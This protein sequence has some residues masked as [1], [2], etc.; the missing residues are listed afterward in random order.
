MQLPR[1]ALRHVRSLLTDDVVQIVA[2]SIVTS[3]LDNCNAL[4]HSA[5]A[6]TIIKLQQPQNNLTRAVWQRYGCITQ[7]CC[8][9]CCTGCRRSIAV[10]THKVLTTSTTPYLH[11]MFT[12]ATPARPMRSA[13]V[14]RR[15]AAVR[16]VHPYR[17][18]STHSLLLDQHSETRCLPTLDYAIQ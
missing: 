2:H 17:V 12:V 4:L 18:C 5:P 14:H 10:L 11:D 9:G 1:R 13:S 8:C 15:S 6:A 3:R 7:R 16:P